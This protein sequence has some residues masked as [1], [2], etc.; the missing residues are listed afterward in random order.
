VGYKIKEELKFR[1]LGAAFTT[2]LSSYAFWL[3]GGSGG[4]MDWMSVALRTYRRGEVGRRGKWD[5]GS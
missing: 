4:K 1:C 2:G 3:I 5:S